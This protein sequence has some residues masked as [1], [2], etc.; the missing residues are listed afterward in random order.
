MT[1]SAQ[2]ELV[3]VHEWGSDAFHQRV[4][5]LESEG[6][7]TREGSYNIAPEVNPETGAIIHLHTIEM[8]RLRLDNR[9]GE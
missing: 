9:L 8:F 5:E 6:Y 3:V 2:D 7:V 4:I 1:V